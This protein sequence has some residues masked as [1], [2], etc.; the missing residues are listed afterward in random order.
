M[1][2]GDFPVTLSETVTRKYN[3]RTYTIIKF[4]IPR[5][6]ANRLKVIQGKGGR[7]APE[8]RPYCHVLLADEFSKA[9]YD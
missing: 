7:V 4:V 6:L 2:D 9:V 1:D 3:G 8:G 5:A